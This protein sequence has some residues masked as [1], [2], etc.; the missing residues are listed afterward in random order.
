MWHDL[1]GASS[2]EWET[3]D[4]ED[5]I[6]DPYTEKRS[7]SSTFSAKSYIPFHRY[8]ANNILANG[9]LRTGSGEHVRLW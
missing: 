2:G 3:H 5:M 9:R 7:S 6:F 4:A 1:S 8:P